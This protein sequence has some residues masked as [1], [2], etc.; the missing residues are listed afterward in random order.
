MIGL[1]ESA[2]SVSRVTFPF[3]FGSSS[4]WLGVVTMSP[5]LAFRFVAMPVIPEAHGRL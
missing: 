3:S 4:S 2:I 1:I 5:P